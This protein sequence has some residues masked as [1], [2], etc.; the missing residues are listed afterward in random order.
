LINIG[1][2]VRDEQTGVLKKGRV[3]VN[4]P[5]DIPIP[6]IKKLQ[7]QLMYLGLESLYQDEPTERE[8]GTLTLCL[9]KQEFEDLRFQLRKMR[10]QVH[11]D[12]TIKRMSKKGDCI[13]QM[14]LQL[15]PVT[16]ASEKKK[17]EV[18]KEEKSDFL[19]QKNIVDNSVDVNLSSDS[20]T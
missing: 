10:K 9:T 12:T 16:I 20:T 5:E 6:L 13:Y 14:N 18:E 1:Q 4:N 17:L 3:L 8:F 7:T 11:K 19:I 2:I 15:F